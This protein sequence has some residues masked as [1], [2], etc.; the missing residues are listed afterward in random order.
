VLLAS[1]GLAPQVL[2]ET[3]YCLARSEPAFVP[4]EIHIVTTMEGR[5]RAILTLLD[6]ST[7][8][9]A[10]LETELGVSGICSALT[11]GRIHV[12]A[13]EAGHALADIDSEADNA[14]A[15]DTIV[16]LVRD[17]TAD[18]CCALHASIAGGRKT[19]GFLLGYT[20]SLFGRS[21]DRLSHVLVSDPFQAHPQFFF[22]PRVPRVLLD[23]NQR[24]VSTSDAQLTLAEI[25]VVRLR[26]GLPVGFLAADWSYSDVVAAAQ[27][28]MSPPTLVVDTS[29][30]QF[31]CG[32]IDIAL[33]PI[34][35]AIAAWLAIR[36]ER[37]GAEDAAIHWSRCDW[38]EFFDIYSRLPD[39]NASRLANVRQR[40]NGGE[41]ELFRE[42]I[43]RLRSALRKT[44]G[45]N[46]LPYEPQSFGRKPMTRI[47]FALP[48]SS[49]SI[50]GG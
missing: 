4:T 36:A 47:G 38:T 49:I 40:L 48:P 7:A 41:E 13:D 18:P 25:P 5:H 26:D 43:S 17:F 20:L 37:L 30:M 31:S 2:T 34:T 21:Q 15:A 8:M 6:E 32:G 45:R 14:A 11:P 28:A 46:A 22:P 39:Q 10:A 3:L 12:I 16:G 1:L 27:A 29:R 42:Q 9:L 23:R 24:P 50:V 35:F 33:A 19:M 44:L